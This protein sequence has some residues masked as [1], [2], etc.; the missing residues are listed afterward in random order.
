[1][2]DAGEASQ[3]ARAAA[4]AIH[5]L[6]RATVARPSMTPAEIDVVLADLAAAA[7]ALPQAARQLAD[8]LDQAQHEQPL[9]MDTLTKT[10]DPNAAIDT[11]RRH[12]DDVHAPAHDLYRSLD[13]AHHETA[14][15]TTALRSEPGQER[16][17]ETISLTRPPDH[18]QPPSMGIDG[19]G[20]VEGSGPT[21]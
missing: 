18:R 21:P 20:T 8:I 15:I 11:A 14:Q 16:V 19:S 6:C 10:E 5:H 7:A 9:Q 13:A 2:N 1:M 17:D 4:D 12:L 3:S